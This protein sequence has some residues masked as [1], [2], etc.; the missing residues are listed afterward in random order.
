MTDY[1]TKP[2]LAARVDAS[3]KAW[4]RDEAKRR[5]QAV[6]DFLEEVL[7]AERDRLGADPAC[8]HRIPPG[9]WCKTCKTAKPEESKR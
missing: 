8:P 7:T 4:V 6:G 1:H 2:V 3:L 5:G 9:A